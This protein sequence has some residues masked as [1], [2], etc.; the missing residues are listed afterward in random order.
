GKWQTE[1]HR[2]ETST[3]PLPLSQA[4]RQAEKNWNRLKSPG[5]SCTMPPSLPWLLDLPYLYELKVNDQEVILHHEVFDVV[6]TVPLNGKPA[7]A[8]RDGFFG[9]VT[10]RV[11]GGTLVVESSGYPASAWGLAGVATPLAGLTEIPSSAQK[12]LTERYSVSE[13]GNTLTI[14]YTV[15]DPVYLTKPYS[16]TVKLDRV[17]AGTPMEYKCDPESATEFTRVH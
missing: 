11:E 7:K 15:S 2:N 4:A 17:S 1:F 8:D 12:K 9:V 3:S 13:D 16:G 10:S 6:R 14:A 5:L